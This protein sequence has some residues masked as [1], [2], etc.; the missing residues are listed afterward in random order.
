[1]FL[2]H[3]SEDKVEVAVPLSQALQ[4]LG[5]TVWLD[6]A[7]LRI[8]DSLRRRI[9]Q[10][11]ASSRFAA[12]VLSEPYMAKGWTQYELDGIVTLSLDGKQ[13]LPPIWHG[14]GKEEVAAYSPHSQIG[15]RSRRGSGQLSD[16][17]SRRAGGISSRIGRTTSMPWP[18]CICGTAE[19][20]TRK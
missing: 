16:Q 19:R 6:Q 18:S 11:I 2:S 8:G 20:P 5:V 15:P 3:V 9:D 13:N 14:V 10:A 12:V 7:E 1:M 17:G 4:R